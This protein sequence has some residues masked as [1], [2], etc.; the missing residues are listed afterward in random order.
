M[1]N[2][3][4]LLNHSPA[5]N[6]HNQPDRFSQ[7]P[8][9]QD[10]SP[11]SQNNP[12][13]SQTLPNSQ[14]QPKF[15]FSFRPRYLSP[16]PFTAP[17]LPEDPAPAKPSK[18][19]RYRLP[20]IL[21]A[22]MTL[23]SVVSVFLAVAKI[24]EAKNLQS[25]QKNLQS[26]LKRKD[27]IIQRVAENTNST[28]AKPDDVPTFVTTKDYLYFASW[29][30]KIKNPDKALQNLNYN[31]NPDLGLLCLT[32]IPQG[33]TYTP[34]F[35]NTF[36]NPSATGCIRRVPI[37][38]GPKDSS[39]LSYGDF[40]LTIDDYNLFYVAPAKLFSTDPAESALETSVATAIKDMIFKN[41]TK[42]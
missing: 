24:I 23:V 34:T 2:Q 6:P 7:P 10:P 35:I 14:N 19:P 22:V 17:D 9:S 40:V 42:Y 15:D 30:L 31:F 26:E 36:K 5:P 13:A 20:I 25:N 3:S 27:E 32:A 1:E 4:D 28:I 12:T 21:A 39:G 33:V 11:A 41:L 37:K 29:N 8:Q 16:P 18:P 38:S